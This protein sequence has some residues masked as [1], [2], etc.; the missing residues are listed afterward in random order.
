MTEARSATLVGIFQERDQAERALDELRRAGFR[1]DQLGLAT[2]PSGAEQPDEGRAPTDLAHAGD[3]AGIGLLAGAC[4]TG[5]ASG[6]LAGA[7]PGAVIGGLLGLFVGMGIPKEE[8]GH[9]ERAFQ[10][11]RTLLTVR[12]EGREEEALAVLERHG[13]VLKEP[14]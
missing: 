5:M 6:T 11:G 10:A 13:A 9:Y 3:G 4:L 8:A 2:G 12:P 14:D 7:L 1:E